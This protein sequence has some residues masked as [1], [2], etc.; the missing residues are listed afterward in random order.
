M[1]GIP[2]ENTGKGLFISGKYIY[3][4]SVTVS[5][6]YIAHNTARNPLIESPADV[7]VIVDAVN[8]VIYNWFGGLS[9]GSQGSSK[10]NWVHNYAKQGSESNSYS[11]EVTHV[12]EP[13]SAK[14]QLYV[15]GNIG[16]TRLNQSDPQWNVGVWWKNEP[17]DEAWKQPTA[18]PV[19]PVTT[20]VH[21]T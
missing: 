8:N 6:N 21:V 1:P 14:P 10:V 4:N 20:T 16:S 5:H 11:Y 12:P 15:F 19:P 7:D 2:R 9:P 18:W 17:L 3:P 13:D